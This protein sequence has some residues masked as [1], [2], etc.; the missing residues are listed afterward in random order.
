MVRTSLVLAD[1]LDFS[2][3]PRVVFM[4]NPSTSKPKFKE[5]ISVE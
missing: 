4:R 3:K 1:V 2:A 5:S